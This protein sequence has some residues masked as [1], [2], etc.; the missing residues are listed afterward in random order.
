MTN[1]VKLY[2]NKPERLFVFGCSFTEYSWMTW[3]NI[4]ALDLQ[5]PFIQCA[6]SGAGNR[7]IATRIGLA[8]AYYNFTK[9]DLVI[10]CW[11]NIA[12]MD[13]YDSIEDRWHLNGN[14]FNNEN[15]TYKQLKK[16]DQTDL[17]LRDMAYIKP[18]HEMLKLKTNVHF[19]QMLDL[20][21]WFDQQHEVAHFGK[22]QRLVVSDQIIHLY[23]PTLKE[24]KKSF[25]DVLWRDNL[26]WKINWNK[27]NI[28]DLFWDTHPLPGE[29]YKF[30]T[31][32]FDYKMQDST[33]EYVKSVHEKTIQYVKKYMD[34]DPAKIQHKLGFHQHELMGPR[35]HREGAVI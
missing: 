14:I 16:I 7:F 28:H 31:E 11:T 26:S 32:T 15:F 12:R 9:N 33:T 21:K 35:G 5:I 3:A 30:L 4:L 34:E 23:R 24:M 20:V 17:F 13:R 22:Q 8:D 1:K 25:Y 19:L 27:K 18:V 29:H 6:R 10:V 2:E